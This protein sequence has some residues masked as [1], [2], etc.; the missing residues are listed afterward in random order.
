[1]S[2]HNQIFMGCLLKDYDKKFVKF[3]VMVWGTEK[4]IHAVGLDDHC[5]HLGRLVVWFDSCTCRY[6]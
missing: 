1:M 4:E 6:F 2:L 3:K 5:M